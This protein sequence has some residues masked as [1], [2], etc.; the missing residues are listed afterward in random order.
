MQTAQAIAGWRASRT[1][2]LEFV[3]LTQGP[4]RRNKTRRCGKNE[5]KR[6]TFRDLGA[7][8]AFR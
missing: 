2:V 6:R 7:M 3:V 1:L 4:L 8:L 5:S